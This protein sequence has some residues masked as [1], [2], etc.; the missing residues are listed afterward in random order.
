[1]QN[2]YLNIHLI[3]KHLEELH[4]QLCYFFAKIG[5]KKGNMQV[6]GLEIS[7]PDKS[8]IIAKLLFKVL[9]IVRLFTNSK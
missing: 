1:M 9:D 4:P 8:H 6:I 2:T 5:K 7:C 3:I